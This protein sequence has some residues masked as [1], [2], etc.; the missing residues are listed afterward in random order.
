M[1]EQLRPL[2]ATVADGTVLKV[3]VMAMYLL[4]KTF[5]DSLS[6]GYIAMIVLLVLFDFITGIAATLKRKKKLTSKMWYKSPLKI[7]NY[8]ILIS[9]G[10]MT[11]KLE[12]ISWLDPLLLLLIV[13]TEILSILENISIIQPRLIPKFVSQRIGWMK[14]NQ[15]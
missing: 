1:R 8:C 12:L 2:L 10:H 9:I 15:L 4:L 11:A 13:T 5:L 7:A 14:K 6:G 3:V